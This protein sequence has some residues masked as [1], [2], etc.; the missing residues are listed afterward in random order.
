M[1]TQPPQLLDQVRHTLRT[2][3][4]SLRTEEAYLH[5]IK[6]YIFF[7][8]PLLCYASPGEWL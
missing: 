1:N 2:K 7:Y 3:H 5:G 4:Y 6:R 8:S